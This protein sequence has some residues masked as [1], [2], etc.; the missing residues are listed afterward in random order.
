M[1]KKSL[2]LIL[3]V[4]LMLMVSAV[5]VSAAPSGGTC[6]SDHNMNEW[7]M[8][9][10]TEGRQFRYCLN[11]GCDYEEEKAMENPFKDVNKNDYFY[12][13]VLWASNNGITAGTG[14]GMFSP[15]MTCT[16]AQVVTFLWRAAGEPKAENA[17]NPFTDVAKGQYYYDAVLWAVENEIT[18][19]TS[20][21]TFSPDN[22]VQRDQFVT[23]LYRFAKNFWGDIT[24]EDLAKSVPFGDIS[25]SQYYYEPVV[26][27]TQYGYCSGTGNGNFT[28]AGGCTRGQVVTFMQR[29][30][31]QSP[32]FDLTS[33]G[34]NATYKRIGDVNANAPK[35]TA[36]FFPEGAEGEVT[37]R[38]ENPDI[39]KVSSDGTLTAVGRGTTKVWAECGNVKNYCTIEIPQ[40]DMG[41]YIFDTYKDIEGSIN[42]S[43]PWA[44]TYVDNLGNM[45]IV[46][47]MFHKYVSVG[48]GV[49]DRYYQVA[50]NL[51]TGKTIAQPDDYYETYSKQFWGDKRSQYMQTA[52]GFKEL[53]LSHQKP[54]TEYYQKEQYYWVPVGE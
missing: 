26:W 18:A 33:I 32:L 44:G 20:A 24:T 14:N 9:F 40:Y 52:I 28:P 17:K 54:F 42:I 41:W 47:I 46:V 45:N 4:A 6:G 36:S 25:S 37:W 22:T 23:F 16:R 8:N 48:A 3:T 50:Y 43:N 51:D 39:V 7:W 13:P 30:L 11:E 1:K 27:A 34:L 31:G 19:G 5:T 49:Q 10:P 29:Y 35:L 53:I 2:F 21:T 38:S 12:V 15:N